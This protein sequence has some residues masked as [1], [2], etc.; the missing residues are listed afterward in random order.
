MNVRELVT[1]NIHAIVETFD[2]HDPGIDQES[3]DYLCPCR[4]RGTE[5]AWELHVAGAL[6][7]KLTETVLALPEPV[8]AAR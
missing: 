4:W 2:A 8:G 6:A 1:T 7:D 3:G 5:A